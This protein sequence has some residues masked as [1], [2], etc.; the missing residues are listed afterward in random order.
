MDSR[1]RL[2]RAAL[3]AALAA[4]LVPGNAPEVLLVHA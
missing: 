3:A 4:V 2:L 1:A